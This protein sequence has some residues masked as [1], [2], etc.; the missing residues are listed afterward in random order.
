MS[1][2]QESGDTYHGRLSLRTVNIQPPYPCPM[3]Q[4]WKL[5]LRKQEKSQVS[6]TFFHPEPALQDMLIQRL[7][8]HAPGAKAVDRRTGRTQPVAAMG[9]GLH[10]TDILA[11]PALSAG[12]LSHDIASFMEWYYHSPLPAGY[13]S[14]RAAALRF[15]TG[16]PRRRSFGA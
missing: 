11:A 9:A 7:I 4:R 13:T 2:P 3:E 14:I 5:T 6:L 1:S 10:G 12:Y 8:L 16:R 15:Q